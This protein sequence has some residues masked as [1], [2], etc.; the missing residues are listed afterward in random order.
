ML[1]LILEINNTKN[2]KKIKPILWVLGLLVVLFY[3]I[4]NVFPEM[5]PVYLIKEIA[6]EDSKEKVYLKKMNRG[7]NYSVMYLTTSS[8]EREPNE[9]YDYIFENS[10]AEIFYRIKKDTL[11]L[12]SYY[13]VKK[14]KHFDSKLIIEISN[15]TDNSKYTGLL[16]TYEQL[17]LHKWGSSVSQNK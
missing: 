10:D 8:E 16:D 17:G 6:F 4:K 7:L 15:I 13:A 5:K 12:L 3:V 14:P 11:E 2:M 1:G 9:T